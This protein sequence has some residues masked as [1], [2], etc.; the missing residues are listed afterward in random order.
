[1]VL[2]GSYMFMGQ[3]LALS[4]CVSPLLQVVHV[5]LGL[6]QD[7]LTPLKADQWPKDLLPHPDQQF[8]SYLVQGITSGFRIG[9]NRS[10][11]LQSASKNLYSSNPAII[12]E[13]LEREMLLQRPWRVPISNCP[14]NIH[15]NPVGA[16][17]KKNKPNKWRLIVDLSSPSG[18]SV[19]KG[20]SP[21]W[22]SVH[23]TSLDN[24]ATMIFTLGR[25]SFL[26][27]AD[28]QEAYRTS[29]C[30]GF[31]GITMSTSIESYLLNSDQLLSFLPQWQMALSGS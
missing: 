13:Y 31:N 18:S 28:I 26:V 10:F 22:S 23:Y 3:L 17:P 14:P 12:S 19:N 9:F 1:M 4:S 27:K 6:P 29:T 21:Q 24:L 2:D 25:G 30:W 7:I 11:P 8:C 20:I 5:P 16:I 15:I